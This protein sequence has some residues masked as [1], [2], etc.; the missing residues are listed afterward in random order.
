MH[1]GLEEV[2]QLVSEPEDRELDP[3]PLP[4]AW[5]STQTPAGP[6]CRMEVI[7]AIDIDGRTLLLCTLLCFQ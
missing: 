7:V 3:P 6:I 1:I 4:S 5:R 2:K